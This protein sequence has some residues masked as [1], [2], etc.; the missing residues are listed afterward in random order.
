VLVHAA[1]SRELEEITGKFLGECIPCRKPWKVYNEELREEIWKAS[2]SYVG[3][4]TEER[5]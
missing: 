3:L 5:L 4:T 2:E 1:V